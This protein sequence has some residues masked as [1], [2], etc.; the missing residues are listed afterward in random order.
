MK[1][2]IISPSFNQIKY[3]EKTLMSV[4]SQTYTN[5][6][7][8]VVDA[9]STDGCVAVV[10]R[11][12]NNH[13]HLKAI[14]EPD[15][16][17]ADAINKGLLAATGDILAWINTDD[18]YS[19]PEVFARVIQEFQRSPQADVIYGRGTR[20]DANGSA[21]KEAFVNRNIESAESLKR[22][23]GIFQPSVF[24]RRRVFEAV[25]GLSEDYDLQLDYEYWIR[26]LQAGFKFKFL[27]ENLAAATV[28]D[29]AKST[30]DRLQQL[31]E[32]ISMIGDKY[33]EVPDEWI[34]RFS[35]FYAC[36]RDEKIHRVCL[37]ENEKEI[38]DLVFASAGPVLSGKIISPGEDLSARAK[39]TPAKRIVVTSFDQKYFQ[40]GLNLIASLHRTSFFS[41]DEIRV[42]PLD[43]LE[44]QKQLLCDLGKVKV[45]EYA[46]IEHEGFPDFYEPSTR[47]YKV[48]AIAGKG[49]LPEDGSL[50]LW[51][52]AGLT[53]CS[54]IDEVFRYVNEKEFF[55]TDHDDSPS[56][57]FYNINFIHRGAVEAINPSNHELLAPHLCSCIVGYKRG[58]R[59]QPLIDD[60][61][62]IGLNRAAVVWPK[63][64]TSESERKQNAVKVGN[65]AGLRKFN[66]REKLQ[67][68]SID[69]LYSTFPYYGHRTQSIYS[70]LAHRMGAPVFSAKLFHKANESS[71]KA[72]SDNWTRGADITDSQSSRSALDAID[73]TTRIYQHRGVYTDLSGLVF[74]RATEPVVIVGNGPSL[75]DF[76]FE[77]LRGRAWLG[78]NAA[79]RYW[80]KSGIYPHIYACFDSV[81]QNSHKEEIKKLILHRHENG[82]RWFFLRRDF[83]DYWPETETFGCVFFLEDLQKSVDWFDRGKITTGSFSLYACCFLGFTEIYVM[84]VDLNYVEQIPEAKAEGRELV[85][86]AEVSKNPNYF[87]EGYQ[88][89]GDRF[90]PPNRHSDMHLRSWNEAAEVLKRFPVSV[91]NCNPQSAVTAFPFVRRERAIKDLNSRHLNALRIADRVVCFRDR[92][93]YWRSSLLERIG[94]TDALDFRPDQ[95]QLHRFSTWIE[96]SPYSRN[97]SHNDKRSSKIM[98]SNSPMPEGPIKVSETGLTT[99]WPESRGIPREANVRVD[100]SEVVSRLL[101]ART[102]RSHIMLD[103]GAHFGTSASYFDSLGWRILCFEPDSKNRQKLEKRFGK[104]DNLTIDAR[105]VS[106]KPAKDISFFR[107]EES[108]GISGLHAF[109]DT[110]R[111]AGRVDITTVA[112]VV[113]DLT[114]SHVDFLK[115]D[116]EGF[117]FSV[118]RGVPWDRLTPDVIECEFEDNKTVSLGHTY[119]DVAQ[120]LVDKGYAVYLSEWHPIIRYG[121]PHDWCRLVK[122]P[123]AALA[124]DAWGNI[125]AFKVDPG[126]EAISR[127]FEAVIARKNPGFAE[128]RHAKIASHGSGNALAHASQTGSCKEGYT[129]RQSK[130]TTPKPNSQRSPFLSIASRYARFVLWARRNN[131]LINRSGQ[132][133]M[134]VLRTARNYRV[135][136]LSLMTV[137]AAL[138]IGGFFVPSTLGATVS[139]ILA[140]LVVVGSLLVAIVGFSGHLVKRSTDETMLRVGALERQLRN[141]DIRNRDI[142]SKLR[143]EFAAQLDTKQAKL[144]SE[145]QVLINEA[146]RSNRET[147]DVL[148]RQISELKTEFAQRREEVQQGM[149]QRLK[150]AQQGMEQLVK[151]QLDQVSALQSATEKI[152]VFNSRLFQ[153][154]NRTLEEAQIKTFLSDWAKP[155]GLE[156]STER[157]GYLAHRACLLE[158]Q[159]KGRLATSVEAIVLR[160]LVGSAPK[161]SEISILEIGALFGIGAAA[162]YEAAAN[163]CENVHLTA[164]D[165]LD[166]Y[167]AAGRRDLL[168]GAL[169]SESTLRQNWSLAPIPEENYTIIKN[170]STD[171]AAIDAARKREYDVLIIDGDHSLDGVKFDFENY[172]PMVRSGGYILFDDYDVKEWPDIKRYV[173]TEVAELPT[174]YRVGAAFRT[175]VFQVKRPVKGGARVMLAHKAK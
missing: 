169:V 153:H 145:I 114:I 29:D 38:S 157:L 121:M 26:M 33:G 69:D 60:A 92:Q 5:K 67:S 20:L 37:A 16:G 93:I 141:L 73:E 48:A 160:C 76:D 83:V 64:I 143:V 61:Y 171:S 78:M 139:W 111:E 165:P 104:K 95:E 155:L 75:S 133:A 68:A 99:C 58:G 151:E 113:N 108:T 82:I 167:Y 52:D 14:V 71:K 138:L 130:P 80:D 163:E 10:R 112:E 124:P 125:L 100:E 117:D 43:L 103:V 161:R 24:F 123:G 142:E 107:S 36:R 70:I 49:E 173:D 12:S 148:G 27:N 23:L 28:H 150:E 94:R 98:P 62:R 44:G 96:D 131:P 101:Q 129:S 102:G 21:M 149:E 55:I 152:S 65:A 118:L 106:D 53:C 13:S 90:N 164:I 137:V 45:V 81:V 63:V 158:S 91:F 46:D 31:S 84:G 74:K 87:F 136:V 77:Q 51:M 41:F 89:P 126:F 135:I 40:Q 59:F 32:C 154:F 9:G 15:R 174:L 72:A 57:P 79:Y 11:F 175:A 159:M 115:I 134:W 122:Y 86:T 42:Y 140:A 147:A 168:T 50:I 1:I 54:D 34:K 156:L 35:D 7:H 110:H 39:I 17:Q 56:W 25:G 132:F 8:I 30:R 66:S 85:I 128:S 22:S 97:R 144:T 172:A 170:L 119:K 127:A 120:F 2:S 4:A 116:V 166:G 88:Q 162:V 19:H 47:A 105:A 6:E 109:R 18:V 146:E 3:I